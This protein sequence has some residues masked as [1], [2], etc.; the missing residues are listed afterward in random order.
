MPNTTGQKQV[1]KGADG[2]FL[3]GTSGNPK[4][5]PKGSRNKATLVAEALL[6]GEAKAIALKCIELAKAG[7]TTALRLCLERLVPPCRV[8]PIKLALPPISKPDDVLDAINAVLAAVATGQITLDEAETLMRLIDAARRALE[9]EDL[10]RE[11]DELQA[12][13]ELLGG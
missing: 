13:L 5:R 10:H 12:R 8:R 6:G 3:K 2:K 4:G 1:A 9:T 11:L 7:D